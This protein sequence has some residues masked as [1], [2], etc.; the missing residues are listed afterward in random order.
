MKSAVHHR[1]TLRVALLLSF[2]PFATSCASNN[3]LRGALRDRDL[4]LT[5]EREA[6]AETHRK[7]QDSLTQPN[8][9]EV[10]NVLPAKSSIPAAAKTVPERYP[11][12]DDLGV[13]YGTRDGNFVITLPAAI[14][15]GSGKASLTKGGEAA[16]LAVGKRLKSEY[17]GMRLYVEGHTDS[18]PINKSTFGSNRALSIARGMSV[19]S[20]LVEEC[21]ISDERFVVVG[22][23]QYKPVASNNDQAGK[24]KNR[25][26]EIVVRR[27]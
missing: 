3:A 19:L 13:Q 16:L 15:F 14:T 22:N 23:G 6:H 8:R 18:D 12:L 1:R 7:L 21:Q 24:A 25:R 27:K 4:E 20:F 5:R 11:E 10:A 2:L 26:V 9:Q 17:S